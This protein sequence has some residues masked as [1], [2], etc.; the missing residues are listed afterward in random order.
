MENGVP[1]WIVVVMEHNLYTVDACVERLLT[2]GRG[3]QGEGHINL[4]DF[5]IDL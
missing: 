1:K 2:L 3:A 5:S 4:S